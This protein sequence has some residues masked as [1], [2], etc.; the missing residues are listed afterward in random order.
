MNTL[1]S[2][3]AIGDY[4]AVFHVTFGHKDSFK[5]PTDSPILENEVSFPLGEPDPL[6]NLDGYLKEGRVPRGALAYL[7]YKVPSVSFAASDVELHCLY[8]GMHFGPHQSHHDRFQR[9]YC[10]R[11]V[12]DAPLSFPN[13]ATVLDWN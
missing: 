9:G 2:L 5:H 11:Q 4:T 3:A 12:Q 8:S 7:R 13:G 10:L 1:D 6:L